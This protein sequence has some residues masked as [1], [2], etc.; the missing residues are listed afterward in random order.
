MKNFLNTGKIQKNIMQFFPPQNTSYFFGRINREE[1]EPI[2]QKRGCSDGLFLLREKLEEPGAYVLSI[3]FNKQIKHYKFER[4]KNKT[5]QIGDSNQFIGPVELIEYLK[6][7]DVGMVCRPS[8]E[9]KRFA[10]SGPIYYLFVSNRF[11]IQAVENQIKANAKT[12]DYVDAGGRF[13][14]IYEKLALK[15]LHLQM[16]NVTSEKWIYY[17]KNTSQAVAEVLFNENGYSDGK[18]LLRSNRFNRFKLSVC[19][20]NTIYHY[21]INFRDNKYSIKG[22]RVGEEFD[23]IVQ[24]VDFYGRRQ[25][26]LK[27]VLRMPY[28]VNFCQKQMYC[29][30]SN[31][32]YR[33]FLYDNENILFAGKLIK[34]ETTLQDLHFQVPK[35]LII[36]K[37]IG[38]GYFSKVY[39]AMYRPAGFS[40][41]ICVALKVFKEMNDEFNDETHMRL[42]NHENIVKIVTSPELNDEITRKTVIILEFAE[43][44]SINQYLRND[45]NIEAKKL[46]SYSEQVAMALQYI[47]DKKLV[48]RDVAARNVLVFSKDLVKI[49]DFGLARKLDNYDYYYSKNNAPIPTKWYPPEVLK[50]KK[51][52]EKSDVY[53]F[54]VFM[55]EIFSFGGTPYGIQCISNKDEF[56]DFSDKLSKG[57][58]LLEK[59]D[60]CPNNVYDI[61]KLCWTIDYNYRPTFSIVL[62]KIEELGFVEESSGAHSTNF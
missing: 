21:K 52:S 4:N 60:K 13:R 19:F 18:F 30:D 51:F 31:T 34:D 58:L 54:G 44:G 37:Q 24:L 50:A 2:L 3:C 42:L 38:E 53:S 20:E 12:S 40:N 16:A 28:N 7:N 57:K 61:M 22:S 32:N 29:C 45:E 56:D 9:C 8:K 14:Y 5:L 55:W 27:C 39:Q 41:D 11:F 1:S 47:A 35:A 43:Y 36:I 49:S 23:Y 59:P 17:R 46:V 6:L 33:A 26:C 15:D 10:N 48:H 62:H 25:G